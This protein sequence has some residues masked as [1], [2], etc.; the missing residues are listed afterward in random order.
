MKF[1][2]DNQKSR[3]NKTKHGIDF[4]D[5]QILW[6]DPDFIEI[7]ARTDD[8]PRFMVI[9]RIDDRIWAGVI[10]YRRETISPLIA[11][12]G[13]DSCNKRLRHSTNRSQALCQRT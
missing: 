10:T 2:F 11:R 1:E 13:N 6:D 8:E 12:V 9:G 4:G 7:P 3:A 5:A